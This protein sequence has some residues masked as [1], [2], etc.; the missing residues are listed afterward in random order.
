M[1]KNMKWMAMMIAMMITM[2]IVMASC[3]SD[4][5]KNSKDVAKMLVGTWQ[6]ESTTYG[7]TETLKFTKTR[8]TFIFQ[9]P[10]IDDRENF[11]N[12]IA[13]GNYKVVQEE[14]DNYAILMQSDEGFESL[15]HICEI[16]SKKLVLDNNE[17]FYRKQ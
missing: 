17:T 16:T 9:V 3:G 5:P 1:T 7:F 15:A 10:N 13:A 14:G 4:E 12:T 6:R 8:F 11:D 2:G